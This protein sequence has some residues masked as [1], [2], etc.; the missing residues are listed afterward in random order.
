MSSAAPPAT[1]EAVGEA[2]HA[3]VVG[4]VFAVL[5]VAVALLLS[6]LANDS[7]PVLGDR[8][9]RR[10]RSLGRWLSRYCC[11]CRCGA[12]RGSGAAHS[13]S[14]STFFASNT[15]WVPIVT[16]A[17]A[18][19]KATKP[20]AGAEAP[21]PTP[22]PFSQPLPSSSQPV[23]GA[24]P[25]YEHG[26]VTQLRWAVQL[27]AEDEDAQGGG[28][29]LP[30]H[31]AFFSSL[32]EPPGAGA[33]A[34]VHGS[35]AAAGGSLAGPGSEVVG[36]S[37]SAD[38]GS[39]EAHGTGGSSPPAS[40]FTGAGGPSSRSSAAPR[41]AVAQSSPSQL[42]DGR[43]SADD[44]M[45]VLQP[46]SRVDRA[47]PSEPSEPPRRSPSPEYVSAR[48]HFSTTTQSHSRCGSSNS[49]NAGQATRAAAQSA[50]DGGGSSAPAGGS[51]APA[52]A[53]L[54]PAGP[55]G[56]QHNAAVQ[57]APSSNQGTSTQPQPRPSPQPVPTS[58]AAPVLGGGAY[59]VRPREFWAFDVLDPAHLVG[60]AATADWVQRAGLGCFVL[61]QPQMSGACS[62]EQSGVRR[63][64]RFASS[65]NRCT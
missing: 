61:K 37:S 50:A 41:S 31:A 65:L 45:H 10:F 27:P 5:I 30:H 18:A 56:S 25:V 8:V 58:A 17:A 59:A 46:P 16:A 35:V 54:A 44:E 48:T 21:L 2:K 34:A 15:R 47:W 32:R 4:P 64:H 6:C 24:A 51:G 22:A 11:C 23:S 3:P 53:A 13:P 12:R 60:L 14:H 63:P 39:P 29:K 28:G 55:E 33:G 1:S 19:G 42:V 52:A 40:S 20:A 57:K 49:D 36:G 26:H 43:I 38:A 9:A 62:R 7:C